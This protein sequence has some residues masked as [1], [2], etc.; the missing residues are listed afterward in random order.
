ML[1]VSGTFYILITLIFVAKVTD[2]NMIVN[3]IGEEAER[4]RDRQTRSTPFKST[5][6]VFLPSSGKPATQFNSRILK[7]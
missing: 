1:T 2:S 5:V 4:E 6:T 3:L 7:Q